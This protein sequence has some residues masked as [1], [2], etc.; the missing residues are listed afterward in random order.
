M[1]SDPGDEDEADYRESVQWQLLKRLLPGW[2]IKHS[3]ATTHPQLLP[4]HLANEWFN[5]W[6][7]EVP[8]S[9]PA[10]SH[11]PSLRGLGWVWLDGSR[12]INVILHQ[13]I[14]GVVQPAP[15]SSGAVSARAPPREHTHTL[16][17]PLSLFHRRSTNINNY[18]STSS[19]PTMF[20]CRDTSI[21]RFISF[22]WQLASLGMTSWPMVQ[23]L[24]G[25]CHAQTKTLSRCTPVT[26][27]PQIPVVMFNNELQI[28]SPP[29]HPHFPDKTA[30][31]ALTDR[32]N[33]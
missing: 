26:Q 17:L 8:P 19:F 9:P 25:C 3:I 31:W 21:I 32:R 13:I 1:C 24:Y 15:A 2:S 6:W 18:T 30:A 22:I 28:Y 27:P 11:T 20:A 5:S 16:S 10:S 29:H 7:L 33:P 23:P 4:G 14:L 12:S